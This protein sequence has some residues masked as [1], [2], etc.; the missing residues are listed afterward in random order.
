M[1]HGMCDRIHDFAPDGGRR[2]LRAIRRVAGLASDS[3]W[4]QQED[5]VKTFKTFA[6]FTRC[7]QRGIA[8]LLDQR[9]AFPMVVVQVA[10]HRRVEQAAK[11]VETMPVVPANGS[12][13]GDGHFSRVSLVADFCQ[14][15]LAL[16]QS[17]NDGFN[18]HTA[19]A[20]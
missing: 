15:R 17:F 2:N 13:E 11:V 12:V 7:V 1:M 9:I 10:V 4:A 20:R 16:L 8:V 5:R 3:Q 19:V 14:Q 6:E 18:Q